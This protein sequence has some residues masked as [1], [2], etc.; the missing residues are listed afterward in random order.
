MS[1][2]PSPLSKY[3]Y[4]RR[5]PHIQ[6]ADVD[7]FVTFCTANIIVATMFLRWHYLIDVVV[8][9]SLA[10]TAVVLSRPVVRWEIARRARENLGQLWPEFTNAPL[11]GSGSKGLPTNVAAA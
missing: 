7:I 3:R 2:K 6:K 11:T 5:P 9:F 4:R 8:G 1:T 10:V